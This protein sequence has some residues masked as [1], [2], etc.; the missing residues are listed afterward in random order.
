MPHGAHEG[1][2]EAPAPPI[3]HAFAGIG[4]ELEYAIVG[5]DSL[6]VL[7]IADWLLAHEAGPGAT[8]VL[9]GAYGWSNELVL[10]VIEIKNRAPA[11]T[12]AGLAE[13]F[14]AEAGAIDDLLRKRGARLLPG[15]MHPWMDPATQTQ[16]WPHE[17]AHIYRQ[18]DRIFDCAR[19][20]WA[21]LQSMHVNLPFAD[22]TEFSRLHAAI[23]LV[24]P[25]IPALAASPP[26][27]D[28]V[29]A[30]C[31]DARMAAY[32]NNAAGFPAIAGAVIPATICSRA[33]YAAQILAPAYRAIAPHDP[34]GL[35]QHEWLNAR[36]AIARFDRNAIEIRVTDTQECPRA[37]IA[38]AAAITAVVHMLYEEHTASLSMQQACATGDLCTLLQ[39]CIARG[40]A[41]CIDGRAGADYLRLLGY[42]GTA[43]SGQQLWRHLL[44]ALPGPFAI[45]RSGQAALDHILEQGTLATRLRQAAGAQ[46]SHARLHAVYGEL[47]D[48]LRVGR[49][50]GGHPVASV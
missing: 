33:Q 37:D 44:D 19:H 42:P 41:A 14:A 47:A 35:L 23:R 5:A 7:P 38:I 21:N 6:D 40:E 46:P 27:A 13:G 28:G 32:C 17:N 20:G 2:S 24:L 9:R 34:Q 12:L 22:D 18:F 15:A 1:R 16:L 45:D 30:G 50:F 31:A 8:D 36:G 49:M 10:H 4:I 43:C 11:A 39:R 26:F 3:L 48:C 25:V 29:D